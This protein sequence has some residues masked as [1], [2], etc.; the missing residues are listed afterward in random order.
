MAIIEYADSVYSFHAS[1]SLIAQFV[2]TTPDAA[3]LAQIETD[4]SDAAKAFYQGRYQDSINLYKAAGV[5]IYQYIDPMAS[6]FSPA[7]WDSLSQSPS[8]IAILHLAIG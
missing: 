7:A 1:T 5:I 3:T 2:N 4:L 8:Q 6:L